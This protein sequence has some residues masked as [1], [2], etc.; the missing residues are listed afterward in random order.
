MLFRMVAAQHNQQVT[1]HAQ[2]DEQVGMVELQNQEFCPAGDG[3]DDLS[4]DALF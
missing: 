2:V 3:P 1:A 4:L